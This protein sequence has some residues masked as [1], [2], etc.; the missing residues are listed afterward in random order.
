[1]AQR[2][3]TLPRHTNLAKQGKRTGAFFID[4]AIW[5]ALTIG[6]FYG[7]FRFVVSSKVK[8][9]E[10]LL[11]K[12]R[13]NSGLFVANDKGEA[14]LV[15]S[16]N[17][18]SV[19]IDSLKYYYLNYLPGNE[20]K[21]GLEGCKNKDDSKA[22]VDWFNKNVLEI[23]VPDSNGYFTYVMVGDTPD[24][25]QIGVLK[26]DVV[27][28]LAHVAIQKKFQYAVIYD[29]NTIDYIVKASETVMFYSTLGFVVSA[30]I[31]SSVVYVL[32]PWVLKNGQTVGKKVYKL[33]LADIHGYKYRNPQLLM[34]V[35]PLVV[36]E[37]AMIL[38]VYVNL[39]IVMTIVLTIFLVS[40]AIAMASP[41]K[42]ALHDLTARTIVVDLESSILFKNELEEEQYILKEDNLIDDV[43]DLRDDDE[44]EEPELR[45][46]K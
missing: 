18:L 12:E 34:R 31:S 15:S 1:M 25:T 5:I 41:K 8:P 9:N 38:L 27:V 32:L 3:Y 10:E 7:C 21:E 33:G 26:E 16:D 6:L 20:I 28:E 37:L 42:T 45:Y 39:Y 30:L 36:V 2:K 14:E 40:F 17:E 13:I 35:M 23:D 24:K 44:G 43:V 19:L 46:E 11:N 29:F 22:S 4:L